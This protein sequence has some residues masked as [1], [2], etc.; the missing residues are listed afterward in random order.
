[1]ILFKRIEIDLAAE[2]K[3]IAKAS[4][5][6]AQRAALTKLVDLF[7]AGRWQECL[8]HVNDEAAFPYNEKGEYPEQEHIPCAISDV[9]CQ[10]GYELFYTQADLLK[11]AREAAS[12]EHTM[13]EAPQRGCACRMCEAA[14]AAKS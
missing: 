13:D 11:Q 8:D 6:K 12:T 4:F 5:T 9:L 3:R 10:C 2:R 1:M 14:R 7:E